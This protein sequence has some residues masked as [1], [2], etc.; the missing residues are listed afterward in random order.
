MIDLG[1]VLALGELAGL[2]PPDRGEACAR[3]LGAQPL[4]KRQGLITRLRRVGSG[5]YLSRRYAPRSSGV[6]AGGHAGRR[7]HDLFGH[8]V[9]ADADQDALCRW[10]G[11][12]DGLLAQIVDHLVVDAVG[13]AAQRQFAQGGQIAGP[14]EIVGRALGILGQIDLAFLQAL[15]SVRPA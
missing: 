10:P 6:E 3:N 14:E 7:A 11:A 15:R 12:L 13:G 9:A 8:A 5:M 4:G 1:D 2:R